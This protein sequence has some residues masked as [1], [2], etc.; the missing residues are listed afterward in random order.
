MW[1]GRGT[2]IINIE[3]VRKGLFLVCELQIEWTIYK[4]SGRIAK[5]SG[6]IA[7]WMDDLQF[8]WENCKLSARI[9]SHTPLRQL[10]D[11]APTEEYKTTDFQLN[12]YEKISIIFTPYIGIFASNRPESFTK[13]QREIYA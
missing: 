7:N 5:S 13:E 4:S 11:F 2:L 3:I 1:F 9:A 12:K 6:R 10:A 8:E